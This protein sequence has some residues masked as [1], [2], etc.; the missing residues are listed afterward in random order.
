MKAAY[1]SLVN[2]HHD[3][4]VK[5][6]ILHRDISP[7]NLM[8]DHSNHRQGVLIDLDIAARVNEEGNPID[9]LPL[10]VAGTLPYRAWELIRPERPPRAYYRH[11]LESF[12]YSLL[13]IVFHYQDGVYYHNPMAHVTSFDFDENWS[14]TR[15]N[16]E[17]FLIAAHKRSLPPAPLVHEW[18][19][20][21]RTLFG[22]AYDAERLELYAVKAP[23]ISP[24][25]SPTSSVSSRVSSIANFS[26]TLGGRVSFKAFME[27]LI[28]TDSN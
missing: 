23:S 12:F 2:A 10:P 3:L 26:S 6:G 17:G 16:K 5:T 28:T 1:I 14:G 8:V 22:C 18:L 21:L 7:N 20:K 13:W 9:G 25:S 11:D 27:I 19:N 4:F 24:P 15:G